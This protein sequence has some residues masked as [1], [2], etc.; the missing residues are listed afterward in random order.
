[1]KGIRIFRL[2]LVCVMVVVFFASFTSAAEFVYDK[3]PKFHVTYPDEW[4][5]SPDNPGNVLFVTKK[6][7]SIPVMNIE[8]R[9]IPDGV[10]LENAN[11][12]SIK[13]Y[14]EKSRETEV[15]V[16]ASEQITLKDGTPAYEALLKWTYQGFLPLVTRVVSAYKDG[17]WVYVTLSTR[18]DS[19]QDVP[20]S[21]TF[22]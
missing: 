13:E 10:S 15:E 11:I 2:T 22:K 12:K 3:G 4:L 1:M 14:L 5:E 17:K 8:M 9:D 19:N 21:L 16:V 20:R 7:G 6:G 18:D